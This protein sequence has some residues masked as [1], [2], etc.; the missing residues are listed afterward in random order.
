MPTV[1]VRGADLYYETSGDGQ[2]LLFIHGMC[3]NANVW[4]DQVRRL[5]P[6]FGCITYDRRGH[7]RSTLGDITQR[8]VEMHADDA[9]ALVDALGIA[10]CV[11]VASSGGARIGVIEAREVD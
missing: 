9:A 2:P 1:G 10:P 4:D 7:S 6:R 11:L 3:G 8:S 5:S